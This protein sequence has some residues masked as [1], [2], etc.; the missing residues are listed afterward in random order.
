MESKTV[1]HISNRKSKTVLILQLVTVTVPTLW[2]RANLI[3]E[4]VTARSNMPATDVTAV[5]QGIMTSRSADVS[6]T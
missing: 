4:D 5:P 2:A 3:L 1:L 6:S